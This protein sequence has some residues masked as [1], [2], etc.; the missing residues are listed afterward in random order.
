MVSCCW[1]WRHASLEPPGGFSQRG[2]NVGNQRSWQKADRDRCE[3]VSQALGN[4]RMTMALRGLWLGSA[5]ILAENSRWTVGTGQWEGRPTSQSRSYWEV[6]KIMFF[7]KS[8]FSS[9]NLFFPSKKYQNNRRPAAGAAELCF[10]CIFQ[11]NPSFE[12]QM[13][14]NSLIIGDD[15]RDFADPLYDK[16]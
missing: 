8:L 11:R 9:K 13:L 10:W 4:L 2:G 15:L 1:S 3:N 16:S 12:M 5:Q 14:R 7:Q 6:T